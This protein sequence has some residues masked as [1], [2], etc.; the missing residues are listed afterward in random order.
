MQAKAMLATMGT[1][2][3]IALLHGVGKCSQPTISLSLSRAC[4]CSLS[5]SD[6][7]SPSISRALSFEGPKVVPGGVGYV[8]PNDK[9]GIPPLILANG[10]Q[11]YGP[12]TGD[13]GNATTW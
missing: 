8:P 12:W 9:L 4:A 3:K 6:V 5:L 2:D 10:P 1:A 11:G 7:S 13:K